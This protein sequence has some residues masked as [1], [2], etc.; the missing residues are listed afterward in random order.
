MQVRQLQSMVVKLKDKMMEHVDRVDYFRKRIGL[1]DTPED[2]LVDLPWTQLTQWQHTVT[3]AALRV[4][5]AIR[6]KIT[7]HVHNTD[8]IQRHL[9]NMTQDII[10]ET[11][12]PSTQSCA[13]TTV[14]CRVC[15]HVFPVSVASCWA[16]RH[17]MQKYA[18]SCYD[19][20]GS[21]AN[22]QQQEEGGEDDQKKHYQHNDD[23]MVLSDAYCIDRPSLAQPAPTTLPSHSPRGADG[24]QDADRVLC[25]VCHE[26]NAGHCVPKCL[27]CGTTMRVFNVMK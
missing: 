19:V 18:C 26:K 21:S 24:E 15:R 10:A 3:D 14:K 20:A 17:Q 22:G 16:T 6:D 9:I 11:V 12:P 25:I 23:D 8:N 2:V 13:D 1:I 5:R 4:Q 7:L 27:Q